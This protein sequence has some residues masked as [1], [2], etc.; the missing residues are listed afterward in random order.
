MDI[1]KRR[2]ENKMITERTLR[3]WRYNALIVND[4]ISKLPKEG[5]TPD[6][7]L[8]EEQNRVIIRLTQE[9]LDLVLVRK[10]Q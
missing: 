5:R 7:M 9:L 4:K 2:K 6:T 8:L 10:V 1:Y 3:R